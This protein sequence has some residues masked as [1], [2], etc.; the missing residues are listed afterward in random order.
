MSKRSETVSRRAVVM[1][2]SI[3][4]LVA[5]RVLADH[6][7]EVILVERD[8]L[9][10][11]AESRKG[12]PQGQHLHALLQR[13][14]QLFEQ[15]FPGIGATLIGGGGIRVDFSR[16]LAWHHFGAWKA[17]F[18]SGVD[19]LAMTRPFFEAEVRR[20][21]LALP[22][23]RCLDD[24][25]ILGL[26][27]SADRTRVTGVQLRPRHAD[28]VERSLSADLVVD[29]TGRGSAT[30]KWLEALG[31][32]PPAEELVT[33]HVGYATRTFRRALPSTLP[34]KALYILGAGAN[35]RRVGAMFPIEGDRWIVVLAGMLRDYP[36]AELPAFL[37]FARGLPVDDLHRAL[38]GMQPLDDGATYRFPAN[39][40]HRYERMP[41]RPEGLVALGDA[42]CSFNPIYGQGMTTAALVALE[43]GACL[44][45][46]GLADL[47]ARFFRRAARVID[48]PWAMST[49]EDFRCPE[50]T[51]ARPPG[52]AMIA[53]LLGRIHR[54]SCRDQD[55]ALHFLRAMHM[56]GS[57]ATLLRP[58]ILARA[59]LRGG[60]H[61]PAPALAVHDPVP[62][63]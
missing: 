6:F 48:V 39:L 53:G 60:A 27:A 22:Q 25:D 52:F 32:A 35:E 43:L 3:A 23:V 45:E 59:L 7:D 46:R 16:D 44:G 54:A 15:L 50:V 19:M 61:T 26:L 29:A 8:R 40:R 58:D 41:R 30:P 62:A 42:L 31:Y 33:V 56:V 18:T 21:V 10:T 20:R 55:V 38:V 5:A 1:G 28:G 49:L 63:A 57:P 24:H 11:G 13:G 34:W 36:P 47:P 4:G 9:P 17:R 14:E 2:A 51:G 12:A 37:E